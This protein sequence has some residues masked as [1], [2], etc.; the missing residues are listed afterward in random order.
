M[1][2]TWRVLA[3]VASET[4]LHALSV[5]FESAPTLVVLETVTTTA[6]LGASLLSG[7]FDVILADCDIGDSS[8]S[9]TL[10]VLSEHDRPI[11]VIV[12]CDSLPAETVAE[13]VR[14]G[15][16]D[17]V[18]KSR[19]EKLV[20]AIARELE[21]TVRRLRERNSEGR[22]AAIMDCALDAILCMD[23]SGFITDWNLAATSI[24]GWS[25][26]E[27]MGRLLADVVIPPAWRDAH[28]E[29]LARYLKTDRGEFVGKRVEVTAIRR[30][31]GEFPVELAIT[32]VQGRPPSC[33]LGFIRDISATKAQLAAQVEAEAR[34]SRLFSAGIIGI[35]IMDLEGGMSV[36]NDAFLDL[37]GYT[38]DE[39]NQGDVRWSTIT[40]RDGV[41]R[42]VEILRE[43]KRSG[44]APARE[45]Q[46]QRKDGVLV[47]A[48]VGT[49]MLAHPRCIGFVV[50]LRDKHA[51]DQERARLAIEA[52]MEHA[53]R[54]RAEDAL[55]RSAEQFRQAQKME[56]VGRFA[57]GV[58]HDFNNVLSV[59]LGYGEMLHDDM[60][61]DD[62][63][64]DDV[65]EIRMAATRA[66]ELTRQLLIFSRQQPSESRVVAIDEVLMG[67]TKMV[68]RIV[69]EDVEV[70]IVTGPPLGA[71]RIDTTHLEQV[72]MNLVVNARDA[73]PR[74]GRITIRTLNVDVHEQSI[75]TLLP[76]RAGAY[77]RLDVTDTG[78]GIDPN[79]RA[80]IFE[81]FFS[82][83][84]VG[85]G[86]GLG[87]S[88]VFGIVQQSGGNLAVSS[89]VGHGTTFSI[90]LPIVDAPV[91]PIRESVAPVALHGD[92]TILVV[93]DDAQVL[94]VVI[95]LLH[96]HGYH[97]LAAQS[98][99]EAL[100]LSELT[101]GPIHL[102][103]TDV[104]MPHMGGPELALRLTRSRP[105][106][107]VIC[108]S[109]YT[110][111]DAAG[112]DAIPSSTPFLQKPITPASLTRKVREVLD[113][114][115]AP[116]VAQC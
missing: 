55:V 72:V 83:K 51:S 66:M 33:F 99:G 63:R 45:K 88:T 98:A 71:V 80:K 38:R 64:R 17:V 102:L 4:T 9:A 25:R 81:P 46:Y 31:G 78:C 21:S 13:M 68:R 86:T 62:V 107:K 58:A 84:S 105:A 76:A 11:P 92:E 48:L 90:Y 42:D 111:H 44:V 40:P 109:G 12:L 110:E 47:P 8:V 27:V 100:L 116:D 26:E 43:L 24:F 28:R 65:A 61:V 96:R 75:D 15:A 23:E 77:V 67:M 32:R 93:E 70:N 97:V 87:L 94:S 20:P 16:R 82:T 53:G 49:A 114:V 60:N 89:A 34:F 57:G 106:M 95:Q 29:G 69:G 79:L 73:M 22:R 19:L 1:G 59:I 52:S 39:F 14:T 36:A 7:A 101:F 3:L 18:A 74:G 104:V 6:G 30:D 41:R 35:F 108:M 91:E 50:D 10:A 56:A 103:L 2:E 113:S 54:E 5:A 112:L 37:L 115:E 85:K